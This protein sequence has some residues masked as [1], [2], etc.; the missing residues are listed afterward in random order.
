MKKMMAVI[1]L[2]G[3][4]AACGGGGGGNDGPPP[5]AV[6]VSPGTAQASGVAGTTPDGLVMIMTATLG[7][8]PTGTVYP[9]IASSSAA[10]QSGTTD[11]IQTGANTWTVRLYSV[12]E[13]VAG[14]Y[15]GT[16]SLRLCKDMQC[17]SEYPVTGAT[18][19]FSINV[20]PMPH[21]TLTTNGTTTPVDLGSG[22]LLN[23]A[24][25]ASFTLTSD[26]PVT[27][28][29]QEVD[30]DLGQLAT[31]TTSLSGTASRWQGISGGFVQLFA[32]PVAVPDYAIT[33]EVTPQ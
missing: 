26:T 19:P 8:L 14:T 17:A 27:W 9:V 30:A 6:S 15:T 22:Y 11:A 4:L 23:V 18:V 25:G 16:V 10:I 24:N 28:T 3:A 13:L 20:I 29:E 2:L 12:P 21:F 5:I 32:A 33:L 1:G 31:T 7:S